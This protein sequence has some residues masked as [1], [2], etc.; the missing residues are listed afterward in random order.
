MGRYPAELEEHWDAGGER[1]FIRPIRPEDAPQHQAFFHR[2]TPEDIRLRFFASMRE[3]SPAQLARLTQ[4]DYDR[5]MALIAVREATGETVAVARL[6]GAAEEDVAEF[7]VSVQTDEKNRG[8][9]THM[10]RRL[11]DWARQHG[12]REIIGEILAENATMLEF[13]RNLGFTLA[14]SRRDPELIEVRLQ[15]AQPEEETEPAWF[16]AYRCPGL[17]ACCSDRRNWTWVQRMAA[18]QTTRMPRMRFTRISRR[19]TSAAAAAR[20]VEM[21]ARNRRYGPKTIIRKTI[22]IIQPIPCIAFTYHGSC[23]KPRNS[24]P[25]WFRE[26][27]ELADRKRVA[28]NDRNHHHVPDNEEKAPK[29][30]VVHC[31]PLR[32][33][34]CGK[35]RAQHDEREEHPAYPD[36]RAEKVDGLHPRPRGHVAH[37]VSSSSSPSKAHNS[38]AAVERG[39]ASVT[40]SPSA[41]ASAKPVRLPSV[42]RSTGS[43]RSAISAAMRAR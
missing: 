4:L 38:V 15:L 29:D 35:A 34:Q 20:E 24:V 30:P 37:A 23:P 28:G 14:H 8:L 17:S 1:L 41:K 22:T 42:L 10:M 2:L 11:L 3:L 43:R 25:W 13:A 39:L 6:A 7:A 32:R 16:R 18:M 40:P 26:P 31:D 9:G 5:D 21:A 36:H 12:I 33:L 27:P 19:M